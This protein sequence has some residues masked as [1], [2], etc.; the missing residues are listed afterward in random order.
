MHGAVEINEEI[1]P[2]SRLSPFACEASETVNWPCR[3]SWKEKKKHQ[4]IERPGQS[5]HL[6]AQAN[7][8]IQCSKRDVR[9]SEKTKL[10]SR[11][12][13]W[14]KFGRGKRKQA[15]SDRRIERPT[16]PSPAFCE[17]TPL[18]TARQRNQW[19]SRSRVRGKRGRTFNTP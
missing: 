4:E 10:A 1:R 18:P 9:N 5:D 3:Y 13:D 6:I 2:G 12:Y 17:Y 8:N 19:R 11:R 15:C 7:Y 14:K 16:S